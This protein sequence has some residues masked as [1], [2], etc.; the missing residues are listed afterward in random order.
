M[1]PLIAIA[2]VLSGVLMGW[3]TFYGAL[4]YRHGRLVGTYKGRV[5]GNLAVAGPIRRE[6]KISEPLDETFKRK[7][8]KNGSPVQPVAEWLSTFVGH[9]DGQLLIRFQS[10]SLVREA[11][12]DA[13]IGDEYE[14][15]FYHRGRGRIRST[16]SIEEEQVPPVGQ[17]PFGGTM[18]SGG[19]F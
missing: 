15:V 19:G 6:C 10:R 18:G 16:R 17:N 4:R 14:I 3:A 12:S 13:S 7:I 8:I 11:I 5:T 1:D 9:V 2:L